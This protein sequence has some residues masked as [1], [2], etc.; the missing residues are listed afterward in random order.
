MRDELDREVAEVKP[1]AEGAEYD[2]L[3]PEQA[4]NMDS[5]PHETYA[6]G[7]FSGPFPL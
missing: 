4:E 7:P 5:W 2:E 1:D 3:T 6:N